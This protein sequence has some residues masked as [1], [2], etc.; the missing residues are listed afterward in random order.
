MGR[1]AF[2]RDLKKFLGDSTLADRGW[3]Q[4]DDL[5]LLVPLFAQVPSGQTDMYLLRL[6]FDHYPA[7]PPSAQFI[8]PLTL[9]YVYP[10]DVA[11][12][13]RC[14]APFVAFHPFYNGQLQLVCSST[15]LEFYKVNHSVE[16][17]NLWNPERSNFR[18]T[19]AAIRAGL[20]AENY[21]GR[22]TQ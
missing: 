8:N 21:K 14:E 15:T 17:A 2:S 7:F 9:D 4:V 20:A 11:W 3:M 22:A 12:V 10:R 6:V 13:P 16:P 1:E 19:L 18:S 5:T